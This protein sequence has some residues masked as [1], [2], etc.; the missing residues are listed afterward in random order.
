M[1]SNRQKKGRFLLTSS[2]SPDLLK[3]VSDTL[4]GRVGIV[5]LGTLKVN[6]ALHK[7]LPDFY[8]IFRKPLD[9]KDDLAL[10][11]GLFI[12]KQIFGKDF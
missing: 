12:L 2:S 11:K 9:Y 6:E 10:F 4:S 7:P 5:E 3:G 8:K 1:D